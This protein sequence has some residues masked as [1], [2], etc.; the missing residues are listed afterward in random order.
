M[1]IARLLLMELVI[2]AVLR[3]AGRTVDSECAS[4][5]LV[6]YTTVAHKIMVAWKTT[7]HDLFLRSRCANERKWQVVAV[8]KPKLLVNGLSDSI[9][10]PS[11]ISL[12][13]HSLP[14]NDGLTG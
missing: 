9:G 12:A 13:T 8:F 2:T 1:S 4:T 5:L 7:H 14:I 10:I 6:K 3:I 11:W